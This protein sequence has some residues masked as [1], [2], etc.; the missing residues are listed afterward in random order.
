MFW[1][2]EARTKTETKKKVRNEKRILV[3]SVNKCLYFFVFIV[4]FVLKLKI[5]PWNRKHCTVL[6]SRNYN[7]TRKQWSVLFRMPWWEFSL[8]LEPTHCLNIT[9][10]NWFLKR[11]RK[12]RTSVKHE[13]L[14]TF[15]LICWGMFNLIET[16]FL[17]FFRRMMT[18]NDNKTWIPK[19][20][21]G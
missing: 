21:P 2:D 1:S 7:T 10:I 11:G 12:S 8:V 18:P 16:E 14:N 19:L 9:S 15:E 3:Y 5:V 4:Y 6:F 17:L 20:F 13:W